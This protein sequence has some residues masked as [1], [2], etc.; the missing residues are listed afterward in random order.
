MK[1]PQNEFQW[2]DWNPNPSTDKPE[3]NIED[4]E[5]NIQWQ[6]P[7]DEI[8][9]NQD[10]SDTRTKEGTEFKWDNDNDPQSVD[11]PSLFSLIGKTE[12]LYYNGFLY[13]LKVNNTN[14]VNE[15]ESL[16]L[17][18]KEK[19][20]RYEFNPQENSELGNFIKSLLEC[21]LH[22]HNLRIIDCNIVKCSP[23]ESFL[24]IFSG[25]PPFNFIYVAQSN[26]NVGDIILDFS[27]MGGPSFGMRKYE[28]GTLILIPGWVPYRI[29]KNDSQQDHILIT[30]ILGQ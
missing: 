10:L 24:N 2:S 22:E 20:G 28:E 12:E 3:N 7:E 16:N 15:I 17:I 4:K 25:K 30:G 6:N 13:N 1:N 19:D 26:G 23:N 14:I 9:V 8:K 11:T 5:L 29:S 27:S 18:P 21:S